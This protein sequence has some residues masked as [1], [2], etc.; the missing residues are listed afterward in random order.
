[1]SFSKNKKVTSKKKE[2]KGLT[3]PGYK[4]EIVGSEVLS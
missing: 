4:W 1:V 3:K 2:E